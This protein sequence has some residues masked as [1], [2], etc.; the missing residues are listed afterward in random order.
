MWPRAEPISDKVWHGTALR[1]SARLLWAAV[2][3]LALALAVRGAHTQ[4]ASHAPRIGILSPHA[5]SG[6]SFQDDV[7][8]GL[9]DLGYVEGATINYETRFADGRTDRL[10]ILANDLV[11]LKVDV[12]ATTTAPAVR[13]AMEATTAIP[14][15]MGGVD[16]AVEQGFVASLAKPGSNV[17]GTS[18]LNVDLT[19]KRLDLL[20]QTLPGLSRVA[21]LREAIGAGVTARA[22][23]LAAQTLNLQV[24]ILEV[25]ASNELDDAVSEMT[26]I[27]VGALSVL[28]SPLMTGESNRIAYL[29][30]QHR[31]PAIFPERRFLEAGG[32]ISYGPSLSTTYRQAANYIDRIL[33]GAKPGDLPVEQ[34]TQFALVVNQRSAKLL[35]LS[36]PEAILLRADD[37]IE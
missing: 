16:D 34:P 4:Q 3:L 36:L 25:R 9:S 20:K 19:A 30:L 22:V 6:S 7:K 33:K 15:V 8:R 1:R 12:V 21:V 13:A 32:L 5:V 11:Q 18:W 26:R 35:G 23:M 10:P 31:I 2:T 27:G 17:T 28:E 24:F 29:A 14:I 37:I